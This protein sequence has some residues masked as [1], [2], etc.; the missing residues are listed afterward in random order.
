MRVN[1]K[2]VSG[3]TTIKESGELSPLMQNPNKFGCKHIK[4]LVYKDNEREEAEVP[5]FETAL[6]DRPTQDI[7]ADYRCNPFFRAKIACL[8]KAR[9]CAPNPEPVVHEKHS[10][11]GDVHTLK[12]ASHCSSLRL[13]EKLREISEALD[14][15]KS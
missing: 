6:L 15:E 8:L 11:E 13:E 9:D 10:I 5:P 12:N 1:V 14:D 2:E 4:S 7:L 3:L